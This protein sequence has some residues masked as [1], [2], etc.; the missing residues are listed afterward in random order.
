LLHALNRADL[1]GAEPNTRS[2]R[3]PDNNTSNP[4]KKTPADADADLSHEIAAT[5][6]RETGDHVTCK[7]I[8]GNRYRCN[9][10]APQNVGTYDNPA[11]TGLMVTTHRVRKSAVLDVTKPGDQLLIKIR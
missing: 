2:S 4:V 9:W 7:R 11:M 6:G 1:T 5:V 10:W 8:Y 3:L